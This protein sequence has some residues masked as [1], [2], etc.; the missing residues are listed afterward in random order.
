[1]TAWCGGRQTTCPDIYLKRRQNKHRRV[2]SFVTRHALGDKLAFAYAIVDM[3][4]M[5]TLVG[6]GRFPSKFSSAIR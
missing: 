5:C 2:Q 4:I 3:D 6:D 1:V